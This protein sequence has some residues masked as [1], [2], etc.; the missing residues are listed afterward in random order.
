MA[1]LV[2]TAKEHV[3]CDLE[4]MAV[5]VTTSR[6]FRR[7]ANAVMLIATAISLSML[8]L[9]HFFPPVCFY[10]CSANVSPIQ[11]DHIDGWNRLGRRGL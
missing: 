10:I 3:M 1:I 6:R 7:F 8:L 11:T 5:V 4:T 9:R 2:K